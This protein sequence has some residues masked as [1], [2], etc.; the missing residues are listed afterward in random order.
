MRI[1]EMVVAAGLAPSNSE[2]KK[3]LQSGSL[4]FNEQKIQ[5]TNFLIQKSDLP[6]GVGL[7]RKGKKSY[8]TI[9]VSA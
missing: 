1:L 4:F 5:D 3:L 6:N 2:A 8:R 9:V 7:L